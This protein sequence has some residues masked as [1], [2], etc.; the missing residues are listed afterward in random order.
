MTSLSLDATAPTDV[1]RMRE[2]TRRRVCFGLPLTMMME[3]LLPGEA[4]VL[5]RAFVAAAMRRSG[6]PLTIMMAFSEPGR[7]TGALVALAVVLPAGLRA[8][9]LLILPVFFMLCLWW[10]AVCAAWKRNGQPATTLWIPRRGIVSR[11]LHGGHRGPVRVLCP[12]R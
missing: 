8:A 10:V 6:L 2:A 5:A 7:R 4:V 11:S 9:V 12:E 3:L 1:Q